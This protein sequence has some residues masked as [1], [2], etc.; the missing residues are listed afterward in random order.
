NI[1]NNSALIINLCDLLTDYIGN[2]ELEKD[3]SETIG[4]DLRNKQ[5][6]ESLRDINTIREKLAL[7]KKDLYVKDENPNG[8][9]LFQYTSADSIQYLLKTKNKEEYGNQNLQIPSLRFTNAN[10][11][12]DPIEGRLLVRAFGLS[13]E[14]DYKLSN[15]YISSATNVEDSLPL[16]KQ[17]ANEG[18]GIC[19]QY[20]SDYLRKIIKDENVNSSDGYVNIFRECY[21]DIDPD[22]ETQ[23]WNK[24]SMKVSTWNREDVNINRCIA[25]KVRSLLQ[26]IHD[27]MKELKECSGEQYEKE[28]KVLRVFMNAKIGYL[29]KRM[30]YSYENEF[31]LSL[32][33]QDK[34]DLI[35][36]EKRKMPNN[37]VAFKLYSYIFINDG[38]NKLPVEYSK[39]ILGPKAEDIDYIAPYIKLCDKNINVES[40]KIRYR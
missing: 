35:T 13:E 1:S 24:I 7:T 27:N 21:I 3:I 16:W 20:S 14:T 33:M 39:V 29:F 19:L 40:S 2:G 38:N 36:W 34:K 26:D 15:F 23:N 18:K 6:I 9:K 22:K 17:Y 12:N 11:M 32:N 30:D 25:C 8:V 10:Q 28:I 5:L 37:N 4:T 31:R